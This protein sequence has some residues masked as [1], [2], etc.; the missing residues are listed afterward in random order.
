MNTLSVKGLTFWGK[1]GLTGDERHIKQ[2]FRVDVTIHLDFTRVIESDKIYDTIDYKQI[3]VVARE[4]VEEGPS[5]VLL[6]TL[7]GKI[8]SEVLQL[9]TL[10]NIDVSEVSVEITKLRPKTEGIPSV[11][12]T[13]VREPK[14]RSVSIHNIDFDHVTRE[15]DKHGGVSVP[16]LTEAFRQELLAEAETHEY[17]RQPQVVGL[18]G[19]R[20]EFSSIQKPIPPGSL[21]YKLKE[22]LERMIIEKMV[23]SRAM[24]TFEAPLRFNEIS[25]QLYE[26]GSIGISPHVDGESVMNVICVVIITGQAKFGL[27]DDRAGNNPRFL[28]TTPGNVILTR[29]TGYRGG[30]F[31]QFHFVGDVTERRITIG[32]RQL[33]K[34]SPWYKGPKT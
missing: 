28:D 3:E 21:F 6:E 34:S 20:Q 31:Q 1:H 14:Y 2:P 19:V 30:N 25:V 24:D 5:L 8:A 32:I 26:E 10:D 11:V 15:L 33:A 23:A 16:L 27:C 18:H 22:E 12:V 7:A 13:K 17:E 9:R 4:V 29:S